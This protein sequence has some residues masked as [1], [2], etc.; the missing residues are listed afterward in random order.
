MDISNLIKIY[1]QQLVNL[2]QL[3]EVVAEKRTALIATKYDE[4]EIAMRKEEKILMSVQAT[5]KERSFAVEGILGRY[6]PNLRERTKAKLSTVLNGSVSPQELQKLAKL[7][8][9]IRTKVNT[10][11][12]E[13]AHN[14]F[15]IHHLRTFYSGLMQALIGNKQ[16]S[17]VDRKV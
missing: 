1:S 15:L 4:F 13:N 14:L 16:S 3:L 8:A 6:F 2:E 10:L 11:K 5:E 12:D 7:E 9:G 17:L